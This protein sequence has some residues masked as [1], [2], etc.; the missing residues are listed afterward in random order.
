M[1]V[2][3]LQEPRPD[4]VQLLGQLSRPRVVWAHVRPSSGARSFL[5]VCFVCL[6][7]TCPLGG[8]F[9]VVAQLTESGSVCEITRAAGVTSGLD[10]AVVVMSLRRDAA[11]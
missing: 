8:L 3:N 7:P 4:A 1:N 9:V 10:A 5:C 6:R 11:R 2:G